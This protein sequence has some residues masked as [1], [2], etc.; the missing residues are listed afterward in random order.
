MEA[1]TTTPDRLTAVFAVLLP[2]KLAAYERWLLELDPVRDAPLRR[3][4]GFVVA[5]ERADLAEGR[6]LMAGVRLPGGS[7][8]RTAV[9]DALTDAGPLLG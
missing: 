2:A 7:Q 9:E 4:L 8:E 1:L 5:D 6:D 3:W